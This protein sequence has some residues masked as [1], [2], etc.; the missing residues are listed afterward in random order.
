MA[1]KTPL[2]DTL[3]VRMARARKSAERHRIFRL[4]GLVSGGAGLHDAYVG[5][6]SSNPIVRAN[7][8]EYLEN[9]LKPELRQTLFPLIDSHITE[10]ERIRMANHIVGAPVESPEQALSTLLA[11]EDPWLR[12]RAE[13]AWQRLTGETEPVEHTPAPEMNVGAG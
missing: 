3:S 5:V 4:I 2:K 7:S 9:T 6:R 8:L 12:S 1:K 11:S 10:E 13:Y